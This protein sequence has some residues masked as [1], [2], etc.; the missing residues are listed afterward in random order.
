MILSFM[1]YSMPSTYFSINTIEVIKMNKGISAPRQEYPVRLC[2]KGPAMPQACYCPCKPRV[3]AVN[4]A[5]RSKRVQKKN[6][7]MKIGK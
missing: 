2:G 1:T 4:L 7:M 3:E 5:H 6:D